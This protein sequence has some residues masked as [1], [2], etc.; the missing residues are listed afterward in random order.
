MSASLPSPRPVTPG[1]GLTSSSGTGLVVWAV[2]GSPVSGSRII[3]AL[4]W[5]AVTSI[6]PPARV[7]AAASRPRQ[8][9]TVS[10]ALI[11]AREIAGVADH[12]GVGV[13]D[14]DEVE[15][16]ALDRRDQLVGHLGRRHLGLQIVGR[17]LGRGHQDAALA[18]KL[19]LAPAIEEEGDVRVFLGLGDAQLLQAGARH[20][21][22]EGVAQLLGREQRQR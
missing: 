20:H 18:G 19:L 5:S 15:G 3:S 14:D 1:G 16:A 6:A 13:I 12:V 22:A 17:D 4:P 11:A 10:T 8:R 9:S 2:C 7:S 21:L